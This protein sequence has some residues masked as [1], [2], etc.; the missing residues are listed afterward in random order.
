[1]SD[2]N[3]IETRAFSVNHKAVP[4]VNLYTSELEWWVNAQEF[5]TSVS[6]A[7]ASE[8]LAEGIGNN[9]EEFGD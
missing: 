8:I 1:M 5:S 4:Y 9:D 3:S 2:S 6:S 7:S